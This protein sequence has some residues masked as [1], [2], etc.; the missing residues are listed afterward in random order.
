MKGISIVIPVCDEEEIMERNTKRLMS[1]MR[2][3]RSPFEIIIASNGSTDSTEKIGK[4]MQRR[5][6]HVKFVSLNKRAVGSAFRE[7]VRI[8]R[9]EKIISQDMDLST[10][11]SFIKSSSRLLEKYDIVVGSKKTGRQKRP[12]LRRLASDI[13]I[14]V[15]KRFLGLK[16]TDYSLS[17][18][19]FRLEKI[20]KF[21]NRIDAGS[22]YV[23][24]ILYWAK[25]SGFL[26]KEIPVTCEDKRK[27][28]FN[29]IHES[30]YRF[31]RLLTFLILES[32]HASKTPRA[33]SR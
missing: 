1:C 10:D 9:Y 24:Q 32:F 3:L 21:L 25:K 17:S 28:R 14:F 27:S 4:E 20:R 33:E 15:T 5:N 7:A 12:F 11:L 31:M 2:S 30:C 19:A 16:F 6:K 8:A 26:M 29:I 22:F 18:K 23:V 13:Y